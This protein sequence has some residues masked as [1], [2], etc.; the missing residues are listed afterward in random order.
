MTRHLARRSAAA[1][2][3]CA[4]VLGGGAVASQATPPSP[5]PSPSWTAEATPTPTPSV[6]PS[7]SV[8][9][10]PS[11]SLTPE[12][13]PTPSPTPEPEPTP[14]PTSSPTPEPSPEPLPV[15]AVPAV[16]VVQPTC[17]GTTPVT[18]GRIVITP[19]DSV[20]WAVVAA[21]ADGDD[22]FVAEA[23]DPGE[24]GDV[25]VEP[26]AYE[27]WALA[28]ESDFDEDL[29][30]WYAKEF[31][32]ARDVTVKAL[33]TPCPTP[34]GWTPSAD[35]L[36]PAKRGGFT[37]AARVNQGGTLTLTGLP[38]GAQVRPFLFSVPTDLGA[39]TVA[40]DGR[41]QVQVPASTTTGTHRVAVYLADGTL[42]GWQYV[43]V[44]AAGQSLAATGSDVRAGL[45]AGA[46]VLAAGAGLVLARRRLTT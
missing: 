46:V 9:P 38:A 45:L 25:E 5:S 14:E 43:E 28:L 19:A 26:G 8:T 16:D 34:A 11:P 10:S 1:L 27:V 20:V 12:P 22:G 13:S 2:A 35:H 6:S 33:A 15:V 37:T 23:E 40:A 4:L 17:V 32:I 24:K 30:D 44:L 39:A 18:T 3:L 31:F 41:L 42:V 7:P 21:G 36:T 29:G